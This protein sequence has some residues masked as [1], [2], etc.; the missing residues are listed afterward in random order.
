MRERERE[1]RGSEGEIFFGGREVY[2]QPDT[3]VKSS[4]ETRDKVGE[5]EKRKV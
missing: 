4:R 1:R 2:I 5:K 3:Y